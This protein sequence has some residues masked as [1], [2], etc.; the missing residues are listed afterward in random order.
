MTNQLIEVS[1]KLVEETLCFLKEAGSRESECVVL[2]L[3]KR[4]SSNITV[5]AAWKPDQIAGEDFFE[6]PEAS[7]ET[8]FEMLRANRWMVAAQVHTH[9]REAFHSFADDRWAIVRH[10]GA[11]SLVIPYFASTTSVKNFPQRT[12]VFQLSS[13]NRWMEV[14]RKRIA[15]IYRIAS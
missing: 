12:K 8:L 10:K 13:K 14:N 3:G 1:E 9:P 2:W 15:D 11:A 4:A 5:E 6:I 7:M